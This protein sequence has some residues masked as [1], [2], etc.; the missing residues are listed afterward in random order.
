MRRARYVA[1]AQVGARRHARVDDDDWRFSRVRRRHDIRPQFRFGENSEIGLPVVEK[2]L[3]EFRRVERRVLVKGAGRQPR[4]DHGGGTLG[5]GRDE[6]MHA[7]AHQALDQ[8][9]QHQALADAR[10]VQP[11]QPALWPRQNGRAHAFV[12]ACLVFLALRASRGQE[13]SREWRE[14]VRGGAVQGQCGRSHRNFRWRRRLAD[15]TPRQRS[16]DQSCAG[17]SNRCRWTIK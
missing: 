10:A 8:R 5:A 7:A 2:P 11:D 1:P 17:S 12:E 16:R 4:R 3:D 9:Q 13:P 14:Q 15:R 6:R